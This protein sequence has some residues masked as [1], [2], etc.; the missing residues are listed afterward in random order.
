MR[1]ITA[2]ACFL[3]VF[4][5]SNFLH[6]QAVDVQHYRF[7]LELSDQNDRIRGRAE[8][9]VLF[10]QPLAE[11]ALDLVQTGSDGK[12]MKVDSVQGETVAGFRQEQNKLLI[13]LKSPSGP[14]LQTFRILY[15]GTPADGLII[16]K[17]KFG[18]RTFFADNWPNRA[19]QWIPCNDRPEDKASVE[20]LVTAPLRYQVV[21][22]GLLQEQTDLDQTSRLTHWK[23]D[24]PIPTKVMVIGAAQ[25]AISRLDSSEAVPVTAWV[26]PQNRQQGFYDYALATP[27]LHFFSNYIGPYPFRKLANVQSTTIFG[28]MENASAI[29][30]A[31]NSVTG[32]RESEELLAHEI[33]HQWFGNMASE[34]SFAHLWLS[35]GFATYMTDIYLDARYGREAFHR[36]LKAAREKVIG[37]SHVSKSAVVDSV[38][39]LMD[40]LN[41]NSY[42][43]GS[44]VLH[45]LRNEVGDSAFHR[46]IQQYYQQ[47]QG[48]NADSKDF[49]RVAESVA[50]RSLEAFFHQ[51]LYTPGIPQLHPSWK[52]ERGKVLLTIQQTGNSKFSFPLEVGLVAAGG[53]Q[54]VHQVKV[55]PTTSSFELPAAAKPAKVVLDPEINLLFEE[56]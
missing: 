7:Q 38:S 18:D 17:N 39:D 56:K 24:I 49:Q 16:S 21:S 31:E 25:F 50:G 6:A 51:W 10:R 46:T 47:Y 12:G 29:F 43:K 45:M 41:A 11:W 4:L 23:E 53:K 14:A 5:S 2:T 34:R 42:Q 37:F 28:G 26:Y 9:Q 27:I 52:W 19:H 3:F 13:R 1:S 40:L 22:N 32:N 35:E 15:G 55:T 33:A 20:F 8:V 48:G 36:R 30:Y 54:T 44:W